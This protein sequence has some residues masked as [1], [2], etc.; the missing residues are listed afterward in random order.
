MRPRNR[1]TSLEAEG[2]E[3]RETRLFQ[4]HFS[5]GHLS[6]KRTKEDGI[7]CQKLFRRESDNADKGRKCKRILLKSCRAFGPSME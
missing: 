6:K 5:G 1:L 2:G 3:R 7:N 4:F